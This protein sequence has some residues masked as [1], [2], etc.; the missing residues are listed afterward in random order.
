[1]RLDINYEKVCLATQSQPRFQ[2]IS[3][4][5]TEVKISFPWGHVA[6]KWWG[7]ADVRP[8]LLIH[9]WL[10]NAGSF[11]TLIPLLPKDHVSYLAIDLPGHGLS[12]HIPEGMVYKCIDYVQLIHRIQKIYEWDKVSLICHSLGGEIGF[13]YSGIFPDCV[14]MLVAFDVLKPMTSPDLINFMLEASIQ[15]LTSETTRHLF[16]ESQATYER[17]EI[18]KKMQASTFGSLTPDD[19]EHILVRGVRRSSVHPDRYYFLA[20]NRL[21]LYHPISFTTENAHQVA[22]HIKSPV[23]LI[24]V[25]PKSEKI[26]ASMRDDDN[27]VE[28]MIKENPKIV[29]KVV[30]G[31]HHVHLSHPERVS[32]MVSE[33]IMTHRASKCKM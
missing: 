27:D 26:F 12:S 15:R 7:P 11:D 25:E 29:L 33:F 13:L 19:C 24:G 6:G 20:D 4:D 10:D 8:I 1:M 32:E 14:D 23:L 9:G 5:F 22:R 17:E 18:I 31:K 16:P 21:K 28:M 3:M 30:P 2:I